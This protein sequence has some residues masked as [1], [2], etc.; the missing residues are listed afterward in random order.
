MPPDEGERPSLE[1]RHRP[2]Q[3][4]GRIRFDAILAAARHLLVERGVEG[5]TIEDVALRAAIPVGSV[6]QY[7]PNKFAVVVELD[8]QD[9]AALVRDLESGADRFPSADWQAET[10]HLIDLISAQWATDPSRNAVWLA[11][12]SNAATRPLADEHSASVVATVLPIV[13]ELNPQLPEEDRD[14]VAQVVVEMCQSL[15]HLA[16]SDGR[17][18]PAT[19]REL[20]RMLRAYLRSVALE[21]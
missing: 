3:Q 10:D 15:L 20:K 19:V 11:M 21:A 16:A 17:L 18:D 14:T 7:F 9:T 2:V 1:V 6:Y 12:R 5:F 13:S 4:R 8:A